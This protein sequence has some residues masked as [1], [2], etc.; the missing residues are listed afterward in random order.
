MRINTNPI[1][2]AAEAERTS[3]KGN[4]NKWY[5]DGVWYKA[6]GLGYEA[7]AEVMVSRLLTK[8]NVTNFV[9]YEYETLEREE[10]RMHGCKC[11]N[12]L[13]P[14]DDKILSIERLFQT[15]KG[16]S[17]AKAILKYEELEDRIK[18][19]CEQVEVI[20]GL[21]EFGVYLKK[22][23]TLDALFLN[24]DRHFHNLAVILRKDGSYR[25]CP[26]FDHGAAFFSDVRGDYPLDMDLEKCYEKIE[27][28]PF[29][30]DFDRQLD[31]CDLLDGTYRFHAD[32]NMKDVDAILQ[33]FV[34]IYEEA[35][36]DRVREVMRIQMRKYAYF[37]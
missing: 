29:S 12:F 6:D 34:G 11:A 5:M 9:N 17:A 4:Q 36:L 2:E 8:T 37:F 7:L 35:I 15:F 24:E 28:K 19:V 18:Y 27:A 31:A 33:E 10:K 3:S 21:K 20:T 14:E 25:E 23:I 16:E 26:I 22:V 32:F 30:R 13:Q 1:R